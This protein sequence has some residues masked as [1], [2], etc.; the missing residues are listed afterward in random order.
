LIAF[1]RKIYRE[2]TGY[3]NIPLQRKLRAQKAARMNMCEKRMAILSKTHDRYKKDGLR[4][5]EQ[6]GDFG[7]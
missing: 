1:P 2:S 5:E 4:Y 3:D 7:S 6:N